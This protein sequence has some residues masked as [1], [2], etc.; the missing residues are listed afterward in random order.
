MR[1]GPGEQT[2]FDALKVLDNKSP[3]EGPCFFVSSF[4][5]PV[6]SKSHPVYRVTTK[7]LGHGSVWVNGHNLGRYP[8]KT[9]V[10]GLYIPECWLVKGKNIVCIY[11]EDGKL[12]AFVTIEA[13]EAA[14][15]D[16]HMYSGF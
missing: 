12:P 9:P 6:H 16:V 7:G 1:G 15:R 14:S 13:E 10:N 2:A 5:L 8:E 11:D 3:H 4:Q